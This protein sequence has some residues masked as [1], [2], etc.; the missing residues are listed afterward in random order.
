MVTMSKA[1][2][3]IIFLGGILLTLSCRP[4]TASEVKL[5]GGEEV[6]REQFPATF[7]LRTGCTGTKIAKDLII[8][9]AHCVMSREFMD[10]KP[11][12]LPQGETPLSL[13]RERVV[14]R[15]LDFD[16]IPFEVKDTLVYEPYFAAC[17]E[18]CLNPDSLAFQKPNPQD[19][20]LIRIVLPNPEFAEI[21]L[22]EIGSQRDFTGSGQ[23]VTIMGYG[24]T[25]GVNEPLASKSRLKV[26]ELRLLVASEISA[27][28]L[29]PEEIRATFL[30]HYYQTPGQNW[31]ERDVRLGERAASLCPGDS[32]GPV[33][34][35]MDDGFSVIGINSFMV[36]P[37]D[38]E[39][40]ISAVNA[41]AKVDRESAPEVFRWIQ[42]VAAGESGVSANQESEARAKAL[43]FGDRI[44]NLD[45]PRP[46][47]QAELKFG[48]VPFGRYSLST[49]AK[50]HT[51]VT[52]FDLSTGEEIPFEPAVEKSP[53][54]DGK[55]FTWHNATLKFDL[56]KSLMIKIK[57][58][59]HQIGPFTARFNSSAGCR[60]CRFVFRITDSMG[61]KAVSSAG[62]S[63]NG[64]RHN[65]L[66]LTHL[67]HKALK[68]AG[69]NNWV[70][71]NSI[72][73]SER[74]KK[75]WA[76]VKL[77]PGGPGTA[78][79]DGNPY[80]WVPQKKLNNAFANEGFELLSLSSYVSQLPR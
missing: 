62:L 69:Y 70:Y 60:Y 8:T 3:T 47:I 58:K 23:K 22:A 63:S 66:Q 41:H 59:N 29:I 1:A 52:A 53:N 9:A 6:G 16:D 7:L 39:R 2:H 15:D 54:S 10:I 76:N 38:D 32:G 12:Y 18:R 5:I 64:S 78:S 56:P 24:C 61:E 30:K 73:I 74:H 44:L 28:D 48:S 26:K 20:A 50:Y 37:E 17:Q 34:A 35:A 55:M 19:V 57:A 14:Y 40:G 79:F 42:R 27:S 33:Y 71:F 45:I 36:S 43:E 46:N 75:I 77:L 67:I 65:E 13:V 4:H 51:E 72:E 25:E 68:K 21:P 80:W 31:T 49:L 11:Q